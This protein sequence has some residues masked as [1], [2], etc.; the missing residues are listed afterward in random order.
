MLFL[1]YLLISVVSGTILSSKTKGLDFED[2]LS[3]DLDGLFQV[4][5]CATYSI[6][7]E[8]ISKHIDTNSNGIR[9]Q[10]LSHQL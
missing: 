3:L 10:K 2:T 4:Q 8:Y 1:A 6:G 7:S 9:N 5:S